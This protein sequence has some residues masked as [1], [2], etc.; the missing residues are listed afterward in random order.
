MKLPSSFPKSA[1]P[2]YQLVKQ[3]GESYRKEMPTRSLCE[4]VCIRETV[5]GADQPAYQSPAE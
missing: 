3:S 4:S 2:G 1:I 5:T